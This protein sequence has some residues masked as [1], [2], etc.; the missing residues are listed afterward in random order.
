MTMTSTQIRDLLLPGLNTVFGDYADAPDEWTE[1]FARNSSKLAYERDVE[2]RMLPL[3]SLRTEGGATNYADMAE[4]AVYVYR[5]VQPAIG[6]V[7]TRN[8][9]RD[10]QYKSQFNP[11]VKALRRS[12]KQTKETYGAAV[13]NNAQDTTGTYYGGDGVSLLSTAHPI[14]NGTYANTPVVQAQL[15]E[16]SLNDGY[17]SVGNFRDAA[18]LRTP[19]HMH[20]LVIGLPNAWVADRLLNTALRVGTADNDTNAVRSVSALPKGYVVNRYLTNTNAWYA[21]TD[22]DN[23]LKYFQRDPLETDIFVD[24]DTDNLKVKATERWAFGWSNARGI[25]GSMP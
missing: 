8:A 19:M 9:I 7:I 4:H 17:V 15:S 12:M 21:L 25:Y 18:G 3:A 13:L 11:G 10:N 16:T 5:H 2:M 1:I 23:G 20:K 6:F 24:F 22:C 14:Y